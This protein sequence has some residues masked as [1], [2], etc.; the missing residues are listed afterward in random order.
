MSLPTQ[1]KRKPALNVREMV[2]FALFGGLM[3][4][5]KFLLEQLMSVQFMALLVV[6]ATLVY[7]AKALYPL[8]VYVLLYGIRAG[9]SAWWLP[10]VYIWLPLW[11]MAMVLPRNLPRKF[12]T[13]MYMLACGV[14]GLAFGTLFA[15]VWALYA[16]L[17]WKATLSWI[18]AGLVTADA[19]HCVNNIVWGLLVLPLADLLRKLDKMGY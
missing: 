8:Y 17:S 6:S 4:A 11:G 12:A 7:R 19:I 5:Q 15:P 9:F 1:S 3:F 10:E 18:A 2:L 13:P 14:H 16:H